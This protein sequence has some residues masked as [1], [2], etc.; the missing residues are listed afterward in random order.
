MTSQISSSATRATFK[1]IKFAMFGYCGLE[2]VIIQI[3]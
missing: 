3:Q 2:A 1:E